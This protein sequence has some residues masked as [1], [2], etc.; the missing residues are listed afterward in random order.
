MSDAAHVYLH[1]VLPWAPIGDPSAFVNIHWQSIKAGQ[2]KGYWSGRACLSRDEA[3]KNAM[4]AGGMP[5]TTGVF[6][7]MSTQRE[8]EERQSK[9]PGGRTYRSAKRAQTNAVQLRSLFIDIDGYKDYASKA[10]AA[11]AFMEFLQ[12][13]GIPRPTMIVDS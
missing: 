10:D 1:R 5:E 6:V 7:C 8:F 13:S 3:V 12:K 9:A 11:V 4:W 2:L